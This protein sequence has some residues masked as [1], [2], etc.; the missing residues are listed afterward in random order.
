MENFQN[1]QQWQELLADYVLGDVTSE[2]AEIVHQLL[3]AHP[4]LQEELTHLQETLALIPL[5]LPVSSP[6]GKLGKNILQLA[7]TDSAFVATNS[8]LNSLRKKSIINLLTLGAIAFSFIL[9]LAFYNYR[10]QQQLAIAQSESSQFQ[11]VIAGLPASNNRLLALQG[12]SQ[13][14]NATGIVFIMPTNNQVI[15]TAQNL[16]PLPSGKVYRL[17]AMADGKKFDCGK[18]NTDKKGHIMKQMPLDDV[19]INTSKLLIT[20]EPTEAFPQ[21]TGAEVMTSKIWYQL[22]QDSLNNKDLSN[23]DYLDSKRTL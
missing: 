20:I 3:L 15:I 21:P 17:W 12:T 19:I 14:P 8:L 10:L 5:T 2:E 1:P 4:E 16:S 22:K 9:G 7:Q 6:P 11:K 23:V 18:L 13:A